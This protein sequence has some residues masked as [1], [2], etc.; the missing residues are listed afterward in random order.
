METAICDFCGDAT[1]TLSL[2]DHIGTWA[3]CVGCRVW[4]DTD[5]DMVRWHGGKATA[6]DL[7]RTG[8]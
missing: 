5:P 3:I 1:M 2:H 4:V 8:K 6:H 7:D